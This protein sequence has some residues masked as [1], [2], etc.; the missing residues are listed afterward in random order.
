MKLT[1]LLPLLAATEQA[2][3]AKRAAALR[4]HGHEGVITNE[5]DPWAAARPAPEPPAPYNDL[6]ADMR[7]DF[8]S[9]R[10]DHAWRR[11]RNR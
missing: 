7:L 10:S 4:E 1:I 3:K 8:P 6:L 11:R 9:P 5:A 2:A